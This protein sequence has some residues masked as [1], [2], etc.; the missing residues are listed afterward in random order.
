MESKLFRSVPG[1]LIE[2]ACSSQGYAA[3]SV[4]TSTRLFVKSNF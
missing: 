1:K 4:R 2:A 3:P